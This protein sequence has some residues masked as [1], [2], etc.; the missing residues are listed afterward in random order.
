MLKAVFTPL[1]VAKPTDPSTDS[2][3]NGVSNPTSKGAKTVVAAPAV[4]IDATVEIPKIPTSSII[5]LFFD[6]N[7][8]I[9]LGLI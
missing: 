1:N 3:T 6:T 9:F 7:V 4:S 5:V 2:V 8:L